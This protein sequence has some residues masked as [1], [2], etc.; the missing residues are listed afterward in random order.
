MDNLT[1]SVCL[2]VFFMDAKH[3]LKETVSQCGPYMSRSTFFHGTKHCKS[4]NMSLTWA[5]SAFRFWLCARMIYLA[6]DGGPRKDPTKKVTTTNN[7][8]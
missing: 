6:Q 5:G 7:Q 4:K 1:F 2:H 8:F 3:F